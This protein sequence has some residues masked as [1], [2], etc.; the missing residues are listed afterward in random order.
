[1]SPLLLFYLFYAAIYTAAAAAQQSSTNISLGSSLTPTGKSS[2]SWLSPNGHFAFGFYQQGSSGYAVGIFIAAIPERTPVWTANRDN[3]P[4]FPTNSTLVLKSDGRLVV[5]V[6]HGQGQDIDIIPTDA[7]PISSASMLDNGNFVVYGSG[8]KIIWQSFENPTNTLLPGQSLLN[9][10]RLVSSASENDDNYGVFIIAMQ[11]D[12]NLVQYPLQGPYIPQNAY[13]ASNTDGTGSNITLNLDEDGSL[14]LINS[15]IN[16]IKNLIPSRGNPEEKT[17]YIAKIDVDG[18]FRVYSHPFGHG[19]WSVVWS[20]TD[21]KCA[22]IG[23]CRLNAYCTMMDKEAECR[24]LP[25]FDFVIPGN[26]SSGCNRNFSTR[27]CKATGGGIINYEMRAVDNTV[28]QRNSYENF[29]TSTKEECE[30]ACLEDCNCDAAQFKDGQC[31]KERLPLIYGRRSVDNSN[32]ALIKVGFLANIGGGGGG[33][34]G[35]LV[36]HSPESKKQLHKAIL[37]VG[38]SLLAFALLVL[39]I[40]GMLIHKSKIWRYR[41]ICERDN[42]G[43]F[44]E[45]VGPQAFTYAELERVTN[46]FKEELGRGAFGAVFKGVQAEGQKLVAVKRLEKVL[47]DGETEFQNEMKAIGKT[48]HRNLVKLLGYCIDGAKRLLV[49]EYM[50]NGSLADTL[51]TPQKQPCWEWEERIGIARDIARGLLYLHEEC[52]TQIIHCDIKPQN[53]LLDDRCVAKISD[54]GLAK[55]MKQDQTRTYTGV[56]GTRGYVAP[57]W[58]RKMAVT[59]KADVY[60]FGIVLLEL[61]TRRKSVDWSLCDEEAVLEEWVYN[62]FEAGEVSKVVG[63][64]KV[65]KRQ[66]ER[67]VRISLWCIQEEPSLRPSMK[68]VLLMLEGTVDIPV[69][70][71][72]TSFLSAV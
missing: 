51:F 19:K 9:G 58:H 62:S 44:W 3:T 12:G 39:A 67:M 23:L 49:Y 37:V 1:M 16:I 43:Q 13:Y 5:E 17:I 4:I 35:G 59:V 48:H 10:K 57:E 63:E 61:I 24:C 46:D 65:E 25:G 21:N 38:I 42:N 70:P 29:K 27:S 47:E 18:I 31:G 33:G 32:V 26:W 15:T 56:R 8:E 52:E 30:Q 14:Y 69:P 64:E 28:W 72:P 20:N 71:S 68:K 22:P 40:S 11:S 41:E 66:V 7:L 55:H 60:S 6:G 53:I 36:D 34:G 50:S 54:F 2:S 45:D